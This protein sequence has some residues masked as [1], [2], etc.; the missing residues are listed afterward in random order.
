MCLN[1]SNN[2]EHNNCE[3]ENQTE[4]TYQ[5]VSNEETTV[6]EPTFICTNCESEHPLSGVFTYDGDQYCED[7]HNDLY[8][9]CQ[10]CGDIIT[11]EASIASNSGSI[12]CN[13]CYSGIFVDCIDCEN[14]IRRSRANVYAGDSYCEDCYHER[15]SSCCRCGDTVVDEEAFCDD[16]GDRYCDDCKPSSI[17]KEYSYTPDLQ[18]LTTSKDSDTNK[19]YGIELEVERKESIIKP[20]QMAETVN[21]KTRGEFYFKKDGSLDNGFEIVSHPMSIEFIKDKKDMFKNMFDCLVEKGYRSYQTDTCGMHL[22]ISRKAFGTWHLYRF[23]KFFDDNKDFILEISQRKAKNLN[24]WASLEELEREQILRKIKNKR[25][26]SRRYQ[27]INLEN[28]ETVEV[29]I[30]RGTLNLS[31]FFKNIEFVESLFNYT[32]NTPTNEITI[33]G[34]VKY[35]N[36]NVKNYKNLA[37]FMAKAM[38]VEK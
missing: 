13:D 38:E 31:S 32:K 22:H 20:D 37:P 27:A 10:K 25:N 11:I 8:C 12:Y 1:H 23:M 34:Y 26:Q 7:C 6:L 17:I 5:D 29:R 16:Y 15:F 24:E 36:D 14:E 28:D 18:F 9:D 35:V 19:F 33:S 30:F 4:Q 3:T 21:A 2:S